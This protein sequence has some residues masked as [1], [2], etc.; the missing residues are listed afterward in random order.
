MNKRHYITKH[1]SLNLP[2][3]DADSRD[4]PKLLRHLARTLD[5]YK[6]IDVQDI[7]FHP[8]HI[9]LEKDD[10]PYFTVYYDLKKPIK[11]E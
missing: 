8:D 11:N 4:V 5:G 1:F 6:N 7:V 2:V 10:I 3:D 9:G